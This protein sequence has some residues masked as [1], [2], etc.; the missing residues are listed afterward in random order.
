MTKSLKKNELGIF[1][2]GTLPS[3]LGIAVPPNQDNFTVNGYC[4]KDCTT[5]VR[6]IFQ[7]N[8]SF[9]S[10]AHRFFHSIHRK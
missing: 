4:Y 3:A 8:P 6:F 5:S 9:V 2:V 7:N 1:T 10:L